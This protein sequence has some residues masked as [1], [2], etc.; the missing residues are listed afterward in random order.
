MKAWLVIHCQE[1]DG[2]EREGGCQLKR[3]VA[4]HLPMAIPAA[5]V[6]LVPYAKTHIHC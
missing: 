4:K 5:A 1:G 6:P 3:L 2:G